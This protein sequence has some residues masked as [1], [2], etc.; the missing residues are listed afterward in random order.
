MGSVLLVAAHPDDEDSSLI[1]CLARGRFVRTGYLSITRGD[2]GQ[3]VLGP[4]FG[5]ELGV[6]RTQ[7]LLAARRIDGGQQ[8]FTRARDFGYSKDYRD[9]LKKW[10]EQDVLSDVVRVI[11]T[12][13]PDV[14]IAN[15]STNPAP[16]QHGHHTASAILTGE[17]FKLA[18][19]PT[20]FPEQLGELKPWQPKRLLQDH[21]RELTMQVGAEFGTIAGRSRSMHKTQGFGAFG[22]RGGGAGSA[23]FTF[24]AGAPATNDIFDGID[25]TWG[26]VPGGAEIGK[27]TDDVITHFDPANP[28]ASVPALLKIHHILAG[29]P[30]DRLV[31]EKRRQLDHI[32]QECIGLSVTTTIREADFVPGETVT[33]CSEAMKRSNDVQVVRWL[34]VRYPGETNIRGETLQLSAG[35][36]GGDVRYRS[37]TDVIG[38]TMNRGSDNA[39]IR[40]QDRLIPAKTPIT[41][42]YWLRAEGTV[43]LFR[44]EDVS[45]IGQPE[46]PPDFPIEQ[47]FEVDGEIFSVPNEP[48]DREDHL[49]LRVTPPVSL[50][51]LNEVEL[52]PP[53]ASRDVVV[54]VTTSLCHAPEGGTNIAGMLRLDVPPGWRVT[55]PTRTFSLHTWMVS[56]IG[57]RKVGGGS[58]RLTFTITAPAQT[59]T[60][61]IQAVANVGGV[62]WHTGRVELKYDHIPPQLLQPPARLKALCLDLA[63]RGRKVGYVPGAGDDVA[64]ALARMGFEV[65]QLAGADLTPEKLRGLDAVVTG[66]RAFNVRTD[67]APHISALFDFATNGGN[68]IVLYNRP[69]G[70]QPATPYSLTL[71]SERVT[72][73]TAEMTLLAPEHPVFNTPNKIVPADFDGWVQE[74]GIYFPSQWDSRFTALLACHDPGEQP[75][76]GS[77][78]VAQCG[79]GYFVYTALSWFRQLPDG[80]PG[81]YRLF[82]NLVSLG[83]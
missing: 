55:P 31:E 50:K 63:I 77:L 51:F 62:D 48:V 11:R 49:P 78:L 39:A 17:A 22:G 27:M 36:I 1:A 73:F 68:V 24:L 75:L 35:N 13:Q 41:Q 28:E 56:T 69:Q 61:E 72:D 32:L 8:F 45:L 2:G 79:K 34:G 46:N 59:G 42:P 53:G 19:D 70:N 66:V 60:A 4:E 3:N 12:F 6:I 10:G 5:D 37:N 82:A 21:G 81:A 83:K 64:A 44:V 43:G 67:L 52:F 15:F 29:L 65:T 30:S 57:P 7:E 26:R 74:R 40:V 25:T 76:K 20:A 58:S 47:V 9:T 38:E 71:S 18:G 14:L 16:N 80:V 33:L 54:E 23:G